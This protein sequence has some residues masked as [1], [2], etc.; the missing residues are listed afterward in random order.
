MIAAIG[1]LDTEPP[2]NL[3]KMFVELSAEAG[4]PFIVIRLQ[5]K[6]EGG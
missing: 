6:L 2:L 1:Q 4:Q 3:P 5:L